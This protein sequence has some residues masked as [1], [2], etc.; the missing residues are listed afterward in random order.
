MATGCARPD[1][2]ISASAKLFSAGT[3]T[4]SPFVNVKVP[5]LAAVAYQFCEYPD[6]ICP[7][8]REECDVGSVGQFEIVGRGAKRPSG[9]GQPEI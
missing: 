6:I 1:Y 2:G 7:C 9:S 3:I 5:L 4:L 8:I